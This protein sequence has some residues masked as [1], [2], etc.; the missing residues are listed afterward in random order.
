MAAPLRRQ[1]LVT[2]AVVVAALGGLSCSDDAGAKPDDCVPVV[3]GKVTIDGTVAGW[4]PD[5][6]EA[7]AGSDVAFTADL[8][9]DLPHNLEV[10][11]PGLDEPVGTGDPV[12]GEQLTLDVTFDEAGRHTYEC[13]IHAQM[14]G[15]LFIEE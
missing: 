7:P 12:T 9:D 5:C 14:Q 11:G 6:L 10:S 4:E 13:T 15:D 1:G 8:K 2:S 3:D